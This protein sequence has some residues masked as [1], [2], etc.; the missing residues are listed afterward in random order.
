MNENELKALLVIAGLA[1]ATLFTTNIIKT[2]QLER[3]QKQLRNCISA[4]EL[5]YEMM[6]ELHKQAPEATISKE[7][8]DAINAL[9]IMMRNGF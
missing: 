2:I 1:T 7:K 9:N 8:V 4:L 5:S 3:K 6:Q